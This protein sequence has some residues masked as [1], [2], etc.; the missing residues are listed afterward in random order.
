[1]YIYIIGIFVIKLL[2]MLDS[3]ITILQNIKIYNKMRD[4]TDVYI[5]QFFIVI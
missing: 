4:I 3:Y 1:M 2:Y 5:S